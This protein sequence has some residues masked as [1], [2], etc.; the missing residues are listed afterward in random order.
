MRKCIVLTEIYSYNLTFSLVLFLGY[1]CSL[2]FCTNVFNSSQPHVSFFFS[3]RRTERR[4][5]FTI[6][7][8][9]RH[10]NNVLPVIDRFSKEIVEKLS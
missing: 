2:S 5:E 8:I 9:N 1:F 4:K 7:N 3:Q 6:H 10:P